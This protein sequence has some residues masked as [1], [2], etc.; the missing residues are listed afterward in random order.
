MRAILT[1]RE[2]TVQLGGWVTFLLRD[3]SALSDVADEDAQFVGLER[4]VRQLCL[5]REAELLVAPRANQLRLEQ[6]LGAQLY[7]LVLL[8]RATS[9]S[10]GVSLAFVTLAAF[11]CA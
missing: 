8:Q 6:Q 1:E 2:T 11:H 4:T 7:A 3:R 10:S 9:I 5:D